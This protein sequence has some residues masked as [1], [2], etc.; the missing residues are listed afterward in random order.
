MEL[1][2]RICR[3]TQPDC[4]SCPVKGLCLAHLQ[5]LTNVLPQKTKAAAVTKRI[6]RVILAEQQGRIYLCL[7][8]G[9]RR[10]GLWRLPEIS[11][12]TAADLPE[13]LRFD[14]TITRYR[15]TLLVHEAP[16]VW[17]PDAAPGSDGDWF[18]PKSPA[19][20]PPLGAPYRR[21]LDLY[22]DSRDGLDLRG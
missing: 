2:Q 8:S 7:E 16:A 22:V 10:R 18:S 15:V 1:G 4:P 9:S 14:Y 3:P 11:G 5:A 6:E 20:L 21:A 13:L 17:R 12:E 19:G